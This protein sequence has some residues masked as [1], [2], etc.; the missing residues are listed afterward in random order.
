Y[1]GSRSNVVLWL[2]E[3][4]ARLEPAP[5]AVDQWG[6]PT[7]TDSLADVLVELAQSGRRGVYHAAGATVRSR[8]E[9]ARETAEA[10]GFDSALVQPIE[11]A[12]LVRPARRPRHVGL[13]LDKL[14]REVPAAS[15]LPLRAALAEL[16]R[17]LAASPMAPF[18]VAGG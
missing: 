12:S 8:Y 18:P 1:P 17:Q 9:L 7:L 3:R 11:S 10:F 16:R 15:P 2:L 5:A 4:L 6:N 14:R 13:L